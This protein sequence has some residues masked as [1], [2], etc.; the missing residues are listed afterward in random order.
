MTQQEMLAEVER[1]RARAERAEAALAAIHD[2]TDGIALAGSDAATGGVD[3]CPYRELIENLNAIVIFVD[4]D[5]I[6]RY[7][8]DFANDFFEAE[9]DELPGTPVAALLE[10]CSEVVGGGAD[11]DG[12]APLEYFCDECS[13]ARGDDVSV[14]ISWSRREIRDDDGDLRGVVAIGTDITAEKQT[15]QRL[16]GYQA[17]LRSLTSQLALAEER[18]R[19]RIATRI[20]DEISQN[21]AYAKLCISA[22]AP[23]SEAGKCRATVA[24]MRRL[25]DQAI[26]GTRALAFEL[27]PPMLYELGFEDAVEWLVEQTDEHP[28]ITCDFRDDGSDKPLMQEVS[29]TLFRAVRELLANVLRHAQA[30]HATVLLAQDNGRIQ[31]RVEDDGIGL[32]PSV[33][34]KTGEVDNRF[35]LL[36]I[37]E[38]VEHLGGEMAMFSNSEGGTTVILSAPLDEQQQVPS[39]E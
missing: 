8:N 38:R 3:S 25:L 35:G 23:C 1:M 33:M 27:S 20:H 9:D 37:R 13:I 4:A 18:E 24:E 31:V 6:V 19:R 22:L 26:E 17:S 2:A 32:D 39:S 16:I 30:E 29:V 14:W 11:G 15:E 12:E 34:L 7:A 10:R 36:N 28:E 21:L 5:G